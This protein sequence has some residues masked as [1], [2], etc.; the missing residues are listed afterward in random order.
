MS[1]TQVSSFLILFFFVSFVSHAWFPTV[2]GNESKQR[3]PKRLYEMFE[4]FERSFNNA[5]ADGCASVFVE[6]AILFPPDAEVFQGKESI[7]KSYVDLFA[8]DDGVSYKAKNDPLKS[9]NMILKDDIIVA[10]NWGTEIATKNGR[11][12][13]RRYKWMVVAQRQSDGSWKTLRDFF[14]YDS[15][16]E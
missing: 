14:S 9:S 11:E 10:H 2:D 12:T 13:K 16:K 1:K 4:T 15:P 6:D 7:H 3:I 5:D 8:S